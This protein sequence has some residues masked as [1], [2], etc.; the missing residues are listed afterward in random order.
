MTVPFTEV[1]TLFILSVY[2]LQAVGES[3]EIANLELPRAGRSG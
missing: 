2:E 3:R 1:E